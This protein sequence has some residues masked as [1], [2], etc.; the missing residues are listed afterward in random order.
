MNKQKGISSLSGIVMIVS[1]VVIVGG[2]ITWQLWPEEEVPSPPS[3]ASTT[4]TSI[5]S[6]TPSPTP[7]PPL[8]V[9]E[10]I[11]K[12]SSPLINQEINSPVLIGGQSD[13]FEGNVR[14]KIKD[15]NGTLLADTFTMGG[16][17]GTLQ[18]FHKEVSYD[19]PTTS[20]GTVEIFEDSAKDGEEINKVIIPVIFGDY[21]DETAEWNQYENVVHNYKFR[22]PSYLEKRFSARDLPLGFRI[23][24]IQLIQQRSNEL[25]KG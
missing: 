18:P 25:W 2:L 10:R 16:A 23:H 11:T 22:H 15:D 4:P 21:S 19:Y 17:Y 3:V 12:I 8:T 5:P 7:T 20:K 24:V 1:A 14:I 13:T 9:N 6:P